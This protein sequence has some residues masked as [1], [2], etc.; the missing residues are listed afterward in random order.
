MKKFFKVFLAV[1]MATTL[2]ACGS[3]ESYEKQEGVVKEF[4]TDIKEYDVEGMKNACTRF[5]TDDFEIMRTATDIETL[6]L[7]PMFSGENMKKETKIFIKELYEIMVRSYTIK[8]FSTEKD[9]VLVDVEMEIYDLPNMTDVIKEDEFEAFGQQLG[10]KH[11]D[12]VLSIIE[13]YADD[14]DQMMLHIMD[15]F[16]A[17]FYDF[18]L[19]RITQNGYADVKAVFTLIE[20]DGNWVIESI[21]KAD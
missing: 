16:A 14:E 20:E 10:L 12:E 13:T 2:V 21:K 11:P 4:F 17:D 5:V 7:I 15:M 18:F 1:L 3:K 19:S 8:D 9:K 6:S